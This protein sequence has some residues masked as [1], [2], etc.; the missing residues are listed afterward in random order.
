MADD[1]QLAMFILLI[2][3]ELCPVKA[4]LGDQAKHTN[5]GKLEFGL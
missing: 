2:W 4:T 5:Y 1:M 3:V